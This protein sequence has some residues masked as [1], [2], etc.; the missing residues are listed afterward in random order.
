MA[1]SS[2][3]CSWVTRGVSGPVPASRYSLNVISY[4]TRDTVM[5]GTCAR[6]DTSQCFLRHELR[7]LQTKEQHISCTYHI[8][9]MR[10]V[11]KKKW[12]IFEVVIEK[13]TCIYFL[14]IY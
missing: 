11:I 3:P 1:M 9:V 14:L 8:R 4:F 12:K 6:S 7:N 13:V 5:I 2:F 10:D